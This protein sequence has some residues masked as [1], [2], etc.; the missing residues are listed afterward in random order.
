M[1]LGVSTACFY[2]LLT[3]KSLAEICKNGVPYTEVFFNANCELKPVFVNE[4]AKICE[5]YGT[6]VLSVHPTMSL[7]ESFML[8]SAYDRRLQEGL[9]DFRRYG[10]IAAQFGAKYVI[11]HGGKPNNV[12]NDSEYCE[13]FLTVADA[14][15]A[16]GAT[17]LQE[18]VR[19]FRAADLSLQKFM[20]KQLGDKVG[21]CLDVKQCVRNGY[22][23]FDMVEAV[24]E[25]IRHLHFSDHTA[26]ADCLLPPRGSFDFVKLVLEL[27]K[28]GFDGAAMIEVYRDAYR[29]YAEIFSAY[30]FLA[31]LLKKEVEK[32]D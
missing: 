25:N 28:K 27:Q 26:D 9:D 11:L 10:E 12:L 23:P 18:N 30:R 32:Q 17:L 8:F 2:P 29:D 5:T 21:F 3:E 19:N 16:G 7:A 20:V 24:G 22:S 6:K 4:L 1:K 14:V 31:D 15:R 13:R